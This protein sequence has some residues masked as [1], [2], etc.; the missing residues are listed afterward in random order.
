MMKGRFIN[1]LD[2]D[3]KERN[4]VIGRLVEQDLFKDEDAI[5][6]F[7]SGGG[8]SWKVVGVFQDDGGDNEERIIYAPYTTIQMIQKGTDDIGQMIISYKPEI[9]YVGAVAFEKQLKKYLKQKSLLIQ[10]IQGVFLL[11][12][13]PQI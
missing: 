7:I 10:L 12:V 13:R 8:R 4:V 5:G 6:K 3:N 9:G 1:G 11:E 2:V